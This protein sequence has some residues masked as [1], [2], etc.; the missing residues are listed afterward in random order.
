[1]RTHE[2][3]PRALAVVVATAVLA[4]GCGGASDDEQRADQA[5]YVRAADALCIEANRAIAQHNRFFDDFAAFGHAVRPSGEVLEATADDLHELR[6]DLGDAA[7]K[8]IERFDAA[9][10]PFVTAVQRFAAAR[11]PAAVDPAGREVRRRGDALYRAAQ[12]AGLDACGRG[13]NVIAERGTRAVYELA[14]RALQARTQYRIAQL[15]PAYDRAAPGPARVAAARRLTRVWRAEHRATGRL[16]PPRALRTLHQRT[17][18]L[19]D[20]ILTAREVLEGDASNARKL[21]ALDRIE[22][23]SPRLDRLRARL[24][25]ATGADAFIGG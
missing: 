6:A 9:L 1:M 12:S 23:L 22:R 25:K 13:G 14:Y 7:S 3:S 21:R 15:T 4:S 2:P 8:P 5:T 19:G 10:D 18:R 17:R 16:T 20:A 24:D 11:A